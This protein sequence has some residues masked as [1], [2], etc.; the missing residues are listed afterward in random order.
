MRL[1]KNLKNIQNIKNIF[2]ENNKTKLIGLLTLLIFVWLVL[3]FIPDLLNSLL[4]TF[5]GNI[6]LLISIILIASTNYKYAI[7]LALIFLILKRYS[8][9]SSTS[10]IS[11]KEGFNWT[12]KSRSD[13][14]KIQSTINRNT[15]FDT[16]MIQESQASQEEVEYFNSNGL[17]PWSQEVI[18]LYEE[19][20]SRNPYIR[21]LPQDETNRVR[22]VYNQAAI[23]RILGMQSE[24]GQFLING[25][26][27]KNKDSNNIDNAVG[28]FGYNSGLIG[29]LEDDIIKCKS[30][31]SGLERITY[32]GKGPIFGEQTKKITDIDSSELE[33][34]I[35]G[36]TFLK[37]NK[38]NP[39]V[40]LNQ[41]ADYSCPFKL[42]LNGES[43]NQHS[44][45]T[46]VWKYLWNI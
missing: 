25:I 40:A 12:D 41:T 24:E 6:I 23:L 37:E 26:L 14:L 11:L 3:Y 39:C 32:T 45:V 5:L 16:Q 30:D 18:E 35:P 19:A 2:N 10:K 20:V 27:I 29:H 46:N 34:I 4:N 9:M 33:N 44:K 28:D 17:W 21:N 7:I 15:I 31:N 42:D 1:F 8:Y 43:Q 38:C 13:F 22:T 36:F